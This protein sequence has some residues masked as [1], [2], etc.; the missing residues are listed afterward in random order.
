ME[1]GIPGQL[2]PHETELARNPGISSR[3][4]ATKTG[5]VFAGL[6]IATASRRKS[7]AFKRIVGQHLAR[8]NSYGCSEVTDV[9]TEKLEE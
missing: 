6:R 5:Y 1:Q 2:G 7:R 4:I 8:R 3:A 9:G